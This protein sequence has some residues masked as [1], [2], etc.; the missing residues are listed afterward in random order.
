M[1][2]SWSLDIFKLRI[3]VSAVFGLHYIFMKAVVR[4]VEIWHLS[5]IFY[6]TRQSS[7]L[8]LAFEKK[9]FS[10]IL[11]VDA[12]AAVVHHHCIDPKS[13]QLL[14]EFLLHQHFLTKEATEIHFQIIFSSFYSHHISVLF[15]SRKEFWGGFFFS[16][17][18]Q[19][20]WFWNSCSSFVYKLF[21]FLKSVS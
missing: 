3:D 10:S 14:V 1:Y 7:C 5:D 13:V 17:K 8:Y 4:Q 9:Y 19:E 21:V 18:R 6:W 20:L 11:L 2:Y 15:K 16:Y 12:G